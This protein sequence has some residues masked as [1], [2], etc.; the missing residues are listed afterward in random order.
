[1]K[2][3]FGPLFLPHQTFFSIQSNSFLMAFTKHGFFSQS[4]QRTPNVPAAPEYNGSVL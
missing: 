4:L 3:S 2:N 1:M